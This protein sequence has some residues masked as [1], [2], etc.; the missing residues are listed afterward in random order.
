MRE[1]ET[2]GTA[3]V[4][5]VGAGVT[6]LLGVGFALSSAG[7]QSGSTSLCRGGHLPRLGLR[8]LHDRHDLP[9]IGHGHQR[10]ADPG[11]VLSHA[12]LSCLFG[13]V[14]V[15]GSVNLIADLAR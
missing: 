15:A 1:D 6:S 10:S 9:S 11:R 14:I 3:A 4:L 12:V 8:R 7:R 2:R 13:V 5:L